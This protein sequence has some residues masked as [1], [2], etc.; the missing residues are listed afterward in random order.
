MFRRRYENKLKRAWQ[1]GYDQGCIDGW[2]NAEKSIDTWKV[3]VKRNAE[4]EAKLA[5]EDEMRQREDK[6]Y[7]DGLRDSNLLS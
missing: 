5:V 7:T 4:R 3:I 2:R 6:A 1:R